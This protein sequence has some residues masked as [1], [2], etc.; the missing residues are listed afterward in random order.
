MTSYTR[1]P[2]PSAGRYP[3]CFVTPPFKLHRLVNRSEFVATR[4]YRPSPG[5]CCWQP[6]AQGGRGSAPGDTQLTLGWY[7]TPVSGVPNLGDRTKNAG[8]GYNHR[9]TSQPSPPL[10][11]TLCDVSLPVN[12]AIGSS[13]CGHLFGSCY[14]VYGKPLVRVG[15]HV[16]YLEWYGGYFRGL[17]WV[18][19]VACPWVRCRAPLPTPRPYSLY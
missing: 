4:I 15:G 19:R 6:Y 12:V 13:F 18:L 10:P 16:P 14:Y 1:A 7:T 8:G 11:G 17:T 5:L 2:I 3:L 9:T